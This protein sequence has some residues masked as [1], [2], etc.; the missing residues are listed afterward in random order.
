MKLRDEHLYLLREVEER[1]A[2]GGDFYVSGSNLVLCGELVKYDF[3][4]TDPHE[5]DGLCVRI[6]PK[7]KRLL[8]AKSK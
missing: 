4:E 5:R 6:A 1:N 2:E 7:G 3:L 8:A